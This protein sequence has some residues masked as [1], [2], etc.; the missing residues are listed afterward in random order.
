MYTHTHTHTDTY[1][2]IIGVYSVRVVVI[3]NGLSNTSS[4]PVCISH[5]TNTFGK[6]MNPI[7]LPPLKGK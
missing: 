7:I 1:L 5:S 4:N 2:Y 3:R 6:G